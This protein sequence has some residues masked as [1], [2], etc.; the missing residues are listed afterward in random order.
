MFPRVTAVRA[1]A[2]GAAL[3]APL[4]AQRAPADSA[5]RVGAVVITATR[6]DTRLERM[7]LHTTVISRAQLAQSSAQTL[8]QVLRDIPG[9]NL[10]GAPF[11]V[12][13]PTG[14][15]TRL[16]G[17]T[18][19]K[20]LVLV[21]GIPVHDPFYSTTQ[22]FK[23]PLSTIERVEVL[24]GGAS[25]TWGNLAVA[26]VINI[27]TRKPFDDAGEVEVAGGSLG[28]VT[29]AL[30]KNVQVGRGLALRVSGDLLRTDGYQT[31]PAEYLAQFPGKG[32]SAARNTNLRVG[33]VYAPADD[34][35]AFV[36]LGWHEQNQQVGGY[37][38]GT[39]LQRGPDASAGLTRRFGD[40][41]RL[42]A[43]A[44]A[45]WI[46]FDKE[47][48]AGCF[49]VSTTTCNTTSTAQP[50]VQYANSRDVNPY[51]ELG[52]WVTLAW[53]DLAAWAPGLQVGA[54][55]RL[56]DGEDRAVTYNR[57]TTTDPASATVNRTNVGKGS[58]QFV[59]AFAQLALAPLP[60]VSATV[61]LRYDSWN[62]T[63]GVATM[64]RYTGGVPGTPTGGAI[65]DA[66][67]SQVNP[68]LA[69]RWEATSHLALRAA[70]YR[71]FRAPGLNNLYRS[72]SSTTSITVAN[73]TLKPET[74]EGSEAGVD[75]TWGLV[76][77]GATAF[78]YDTK[79]LV[80]SYRITSAATA[81]AD[82][83]AICGA[84]LSGCPATVN[85]NTNGQDARSEGVELTGRWQA[86]RAL[87]LTA[88]AVRTDSRYVAVRTTDPVGVQLGAVPRTVGT[89]AADWQVTPAWTLNASVRAASAMYLDVTQAIPEAR[90]GV[91][92]LATS[93]RATRR[94]E[95]FVA[96]VN[97]TDARY[98][99]NGTT[100]ASGRTLAL[101]RSVTS[102][103]RVRF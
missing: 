73:P 13:D 4:R 48:G 79:D 82:V 23:V 15:Q 77:L 97:L 59:G 60:G 98:A 103:V 75:L 25:S 88:S 10:P 50:L 85:F 3:A 52:G 19:S 35:S 72:F 27:I 31:T 95:L 21:D 20:V 26:G 22:W 8:D 45:Q 61:S 42:E 101:G 80:A 53:S 71:A 9:L 81:P 39:N 46:D 84:T 58:Q 76:T 56:L 14:H 47:N 55:T 74:L 41:P 2:L 70:A 37:V 32:A 36:N 62:N 83:L 68:G 63:G 89:L 64:T 40:G 78:R 100:S 34:W 33:A 65:A 12:S 90:Q 7:P 28:T 11:F 51:R 57:P 1:L 24:R 54:D 66:S 93:W 17:V 5:T 16:R 96:A 43:R 94:A 44:W 87:A 67:L 102:G 99:D 91:V 29:A 18:N 69:V 30:W 86:T 92:N 49:L 38:S 6:G